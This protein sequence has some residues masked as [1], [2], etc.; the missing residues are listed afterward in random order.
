MPFSLKVAV[1]K[2]CQ[3]C[4]KE[5]ET[6]RPIR[7]YCE[8]CSPFGKYKIRYRDLYTNTARAISLSKKE[9]AII[10]L[11]A[12]V[13]VDDAEISSVLKIKA[14]N[15][16]LFKNRTDVKSY[17]TY[18]ILERTGEMFKGADRL[19]WKILN[20]AFRRGSKKDPVDIVKMIW[21]HQKKNIPEKSI[22]PEDAVMKEL[23]TLANKIPDAKDIEK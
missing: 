9:I 11:L 3:R 18:L 2:I 8:V 5:F 14:S 22:S 19:A 16:A 15:L 12:T 4:N 7:R 10:N 23:E 17:L 13:F 6:V 20:D 1:K 21:E